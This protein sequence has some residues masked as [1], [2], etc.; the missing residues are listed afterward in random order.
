MKQFGGAPV[1]LRLCRRMNV[2]SPPLLPTQAHIPLFW[3]IQH[4]EPKLKY[5]HAVII[6]ADGKVVLYG[7]A[8][9]QDSGIIMS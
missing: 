5:L 7:R 6:P 8:V 2:D 9:V 3:S 4:D 1:P